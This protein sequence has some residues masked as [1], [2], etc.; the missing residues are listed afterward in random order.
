MQRV[1]QFGETVPGYDF[2]VIN[3]REA[4]ASAG[5]MFLFGIISFLI[6]VLRQD[7]FWAELFS[8]TFL[9]EFVI[10]VFVRPRYAP[11]MILGS[12]FV[13]N[14]SPEW[15]E[16]RPKKF[17]WVLGLILGAVMAWFI[18]TGTF[19][20]IR[21]LTCVACL[22]LLFVESAFGIC[23]GC[24]LYKRFHVDLQKC[25]G[26]VCETPAPRRGRLAP[27]LALLAVFG[28]IFYGVYVELK[29]RAHPT[30]APRMAQAAAEARGSLEQMIARGQGAVPAE[31][32]PEA[33]SHTQETTTGTDPKEDECTPPDWAVA[34][35]HKEMWKEHH[36]C[37]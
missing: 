30:P 13:A 9:A 5:I 35:G 14:Q 27:R 32:A 15:V 7:L 29:R 1:L 12:L 8:L 22:I 20:P 16:A 19:S 24:A 11:Y 10:R 21:M 6:F 33:V 31:T 34:M 23:L 26:D 25:P 2:P 17:A 37:K 3:E 36:G 28:M 4:R 18:L